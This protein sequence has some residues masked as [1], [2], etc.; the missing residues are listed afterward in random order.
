MRLVGL[1]WRD[2]WASP[3][4]MFLLSLGVAVGVAALA[5]ILA[6]S[7]GVES[8]VMH[9]ILGV[10]P[11]QVVVEPA[12]TAIG[13]LQWATGPPLDDLVI[14]KLE[15]LRGVRAVYRRLRIPLPAQINADYGGK[16][17]Y[18][19][20]LVEAVDQQ[21]V[22][23]DM[24][25]VGAF[26]VHPPDQAIPVVLP[27]AMIDILNMGF[28]VNTGLPEINPSVIVG[29]HFLLTVGSSSFRS[30][31][32]IV[33]RCEIVGIS[34][35][36]F[37]GGPSIPRGYVAQLDSLLRG[38]GGGVPPM[39]ASSLT[40]M[41]TD[42]SNLP[43]VSEEIR[44][45]GLGV[46]QQDKARTLGVVIRAITLTLGTFAG[47]ILLVAATGIG[48][49]M[50]LTVRDEAG[51]IGLFRAVGAS[52]GQIRA[53]YLMRAGTVG[54]C[55]GVAGL[56]VT[57]TVT[58][59]VNGMSERLVPGLVS[60]NERIL[61]L[62]CPHVLGCLAFGLLVSLL[63]GFLPARQAARLDPAAVLRER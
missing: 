55:G 26:A 42:P 12:R 44:R 57:V 43:T 39:A 38:R 31:P 47:L 34:P 4:R 52:R 5:L 25:Q 10:L 24:P 32:S 27:S 17:F 7:N 59:I 40:L 3:V 54:L 45:L 21:L 23:P 6:L 9:K 1:A 61:A 56:V 60:G 30:G 49:G 50:A 20:V 33:R 37:V 11:D 8:I 19:D 18:S 58:L 13:P 51:E 46:P 63:A 16:K 2:A 29:R 62:S 41:L 36:V 14:S 35:R 48:N 53:L 28:S 22:E 15:K